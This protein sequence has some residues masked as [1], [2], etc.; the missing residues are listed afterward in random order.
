MIA[1]TISAETR[2]D[3]S[4]PIYISTEIKSGIGIHVTGIPNREMKEML[5]RTITALQSLGYRIPGKK[6]V[7]SIKSEADI[8]RPSYLDLPVAMTIL[9]ASGQLSLPL[10]DKHIVTGEL[11][12]DGNIRRTSD[13]EALTSLAESMNL[14]G[15]VTAQNT[16]GSF[17]EATGILSGT[18]KAPQ[19]TKVFVLYQDWANETDQG[20]SV[21]GVFM[22]RTASLK[23]M[24]SMITS[25]KNH[26]PLSDKC[27]QEEKSETRYETWKDGE[28]ADYHQK[29]EITEHPMISETIE[30]NM[31]FGEHA[32]NAYETNPGENAEKAIEEATGGC[33]MFISRKFFST[34]EKKAYLAGIEDCYGWEAYIETDRKL[35]L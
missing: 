22:D 15:V 31:L 19:A 35:N 10:L 2:P 27:D 11:G 13:S 23:T 21:I 16:E 26:D 24:E 25:F 33:H 6:I 34:E 18:K 28:Y 1:K 29:Y 14:S 30:V 4:C 12:L 7:I 32:V 17:A 20:S 9:A 8:T 5:L 3:G